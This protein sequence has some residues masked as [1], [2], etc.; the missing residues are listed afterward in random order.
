[1]V[2]KVKCYSCNVVTVNGVPVHE[3][4]C[5]EPLTQLINE[6]GKIFY[7]FRLRTYDVWGNRTDGYEVNDTRDS[8]VRVI[9]PDDC[10][11]EDVIKALKAE[12]FLN[13]RMRNSTL[14]TDWQTPGVCELEWAV[15]GEPIGRLEAM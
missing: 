4:G 2:Y 13:K 3:T 14:E 15:T 9:L 10:M 6:K 5:P 7:Q 1:M 8:G 12:G 11:H